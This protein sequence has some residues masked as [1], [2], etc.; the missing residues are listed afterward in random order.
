MQLCSSNH[1]KQIYVEE[2]EKVRLLHK[3]DVS[4]VKIVC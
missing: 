4:L 2:D 3:T 1:E